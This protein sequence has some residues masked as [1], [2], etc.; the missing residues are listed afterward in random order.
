MLVNL[1]KLLVLKKGKYGSDPK[2]Y[3]NDII[4][5]CYISSRGF[6]YKALREALKQTGE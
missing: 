3:T 1:L 2:Y 5:F 4:N 6:G